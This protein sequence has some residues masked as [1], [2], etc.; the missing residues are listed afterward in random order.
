MSSAIL[1]STSFIT[2]P[3]EFGIISFLGVYE[4]IGDVSVIPYPS[5]IFIPRVRKSSVTCGFNLDPPET[6]NLICPPKPSLTFLNI[7]LLKLK[8]FIFLASLKINLVIPFEFIVSIIFLCI[9]SQSLGTPINIVTLYFFIASIKATEDISSRNTIVAEYRSGITPVPKSG[10][11]WCKGN[12]AIVTSV[13]S[14]IL[15]TSSESTFAR[16]LSNVSITPLGFPVVPDVYKISAV[17]SLSGELI[18]KLASIFSS[19]LIL[20]NSISST[21]TSST[22]L[23]KIVKASSTFSSCPFEVNIFSTSELSI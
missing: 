9:T 3:A 19:I 14:Y 6:K 2:L 20:S 1:T 7:F 13:S 23:F 16:I 10:K 17:S 15:Y 11:I 8:E 22:F 18:T 4:I 12:S 21:I 5:Q